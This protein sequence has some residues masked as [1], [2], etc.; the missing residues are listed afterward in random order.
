MFFLIDIREPN[1][2]RDKLRRAKGKFFPMPGDQKEFPAEISRA[3]A[4]G[5]K[6]PECFS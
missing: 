3:Y 5:E 4:E 1:L 6:I 2:I